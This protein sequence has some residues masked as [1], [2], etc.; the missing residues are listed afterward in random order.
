MRLAN[1]SF[2]KWL[3]I[4]VVMT[5][6]APLGARADRLEEHAEKERLRSAQAAAELRETETVATIRAAGAAAAEKEAAARAAAAAAAAAS[7]VCWG[8]A[9]R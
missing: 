5:V 4:L 3:A 8:C 6:S 7:N 9:K 1:P 2:P